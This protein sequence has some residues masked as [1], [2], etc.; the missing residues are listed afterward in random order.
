MVQE[1]VVYFLY[2]TEFPSFL[3]V[4]SCGA[5]TNGSQYNGRMSANDIG[6]G[7]V[8]VYR[9]VCHFTCLA[10][11][12]RMKI[13][14]SYLLSPDVYFEGKQDGTEFVFVLKCIVLFYQFQTAQ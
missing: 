8:N 10:T 11:N 3:A 7:Y 6:K 9:P 5:A 1:S 2:V 12:G 13:K 4:N 14:T